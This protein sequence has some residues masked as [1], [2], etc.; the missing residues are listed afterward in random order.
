MRPPQPI[1]GYML[2][3]PAA[4][5]VRMMICLVLITFVSPSVAC[6]ADDAAAAYSLWLRGNYQE[7]LEKYQALEKSD[8]IAATI[9]KARC[10]AAEGHWDKAESILRES[11]K[12]AE[13]PLLLARLAEIQLERGLYADALTSAERAI[14]ADPREL[15]ARWVRVSVYMVTGRDNAVSNEIEWFVRYYNESQ[16]TDP[17]TLLIIAQA[18]AEYARRNKLPE[19]FDFI[20]N[21]L[22]PDAAKAHEHYWPAHA[23]AGRLLLEKYNREEGI[24]ELKEALKKNP[25]AVPALVALGRAAHDEYDFADGHLHADQALA[26][27]PRHCD[28]LRLK[29]DLLLA[30]GKTDEALAFLERARQVN[31]ASEETGARLV[32]HRLLKGDATD[33]NRIEKQVLAVNPRPGLFY[34]HV[35]ERLE[36][37]QRFDAAQQYFKRAIEAA[38]HL[39]GPRNG[40]GMLLMRVG[41]EDEA[42]AVFAAARAIDPFHVRVLNMIKVLRHLEEYETIQT[43]HYEVLV[44][45]KED[46]LLGRMAAAYLESQHEVLCRQFGHHPTN[47]ARIEILVNHQWFS[48]RIVGLPR[49]DI[50]GACTGKVVAMVSPRSLPQPFNWARVLRHEV[51]HVLTL[52]QTHFNIPHWY[53]EALAVRVEGYPRPQIWNDLLV[54]RVPKGELFTLDTI[55]MAF[56]RPKTPLDWQMAYCQSLLYSDYMIARA[57]EKS[58]ADL[59]AAYRDGI[60]T[61]EAIPKVFGVSVQEFEKGYR[62]FLQAEIAKLRH[63]RDVAPRSFVEAE[64]A[65][66]ANNK[67]ADAAAE[68]AWHYYQRKSPLQ[69]R[70]HANAALALQKHHPLACVVLASMERDIGRLDEAAALLEPALDRKIPHLRLL[71][72]LA[73]LQV[74]RKDYAAAADLY[75]L[76]RQLEPQAQRWIEGLARSHLLAKDEGKLALAL[77]SLA[78]MDSDNLAARRKLAEIAE[79]NGNWADAERWAREVLHINVADVTAQQTLGRALLARNEPRAAL[80]ML[81]PAVEF[82]PENVELVVLLAQAYLGTQNAGKARELLRRALDRA[83]THER[84]LQL[85][86]GLD[87]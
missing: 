82:Q 68:L 51:T 17:D 72:L 45:T 56:A 73:D 35:A 40:L 34:F 77:K 3:T 69:S 79:K 85:W 18:S 36:K 2:E 46:G 54:Q 57:G 39:A 76:G 65:W 29:A 75:A 5:N 87:K 86:K 27:N 67:D 23:F 48:G 49:V 47:R 28:A 15:V 22:L 33:A 62:A 55:N 9:G 4:A 60:E 12:A 74:R 83:P 14:A 58:L 13:H 52:E 81:E 42:R 7:A 78:G 1:D 70:E 16:P 66:R 32:A 64:R 20:L 30:D 63:G 25:N 80:A 44:R 10:L 21:D 24:P 50:V 84:A 71:E 19:E 41:K 37:R 6:H 11:L 61:R 59:L 8:A 31:A 43:P 38:P 53:T 26:V